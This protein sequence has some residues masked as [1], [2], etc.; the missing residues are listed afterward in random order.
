[1]YTDLTAFG[2][3]SRPR[4][5]FSHTIFLI[6]AN[7]VLRLLSEFSKPPGA[8]YRQQQAVQHPG[9]FQPQGKTAN[10]FLLHVSS[11]YA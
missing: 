5:G 10:I 3:Y 1:M 9:D 11:S 2:M 6:R 4:S 8:L 7:Q